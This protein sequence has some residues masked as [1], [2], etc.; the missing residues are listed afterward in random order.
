MED[1]SVNSAI[2]E[3]MPLAIN[4][5]KKFSRGVPF[6]RHDM[7]SEALLVLVLAVQEHL[8]HPNFIA[9]LKVRLRGA[10]L[11]MLKVHE[12]DIPYDDIFPTHDNY[13]KLYL[14]DLMQ[15]FSK[16][17]LKVIT[18]RVDGY[19]DQEIADDFGVSRTAIVKRRLTICQKILAQGEQYGLIRSKKSLSSR[20]H[21][22]VESSGWDSLGD[23]G[24]TDTGS[25]HK[26]TAR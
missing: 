15:I 4:Y 8:D 14:N 19:T 12:P 21:D 13:S 1:A 17:E 6:M 20:K 18:M 26:E 5:A 25:T 23:S 3:N 7:I 22:S 16:E 11:D 10:L 9:Y 24:N 2:L